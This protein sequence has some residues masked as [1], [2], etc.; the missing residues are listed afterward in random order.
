[1]SPDSRRCARLRPDL[2]LDRCRA[3]KRGIFFNDCAV[4]FLF[5]VDAHPPGGP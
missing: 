3:G 2:F 1:M 4:I 5:C